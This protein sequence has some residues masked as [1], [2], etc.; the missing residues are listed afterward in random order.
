MRTKLILIFT[1]LSLS[2]CIDNYN[3]DPQEDSVYDSYGN[4]GFEDGL[5]HWY[6]H[7]NTFSSITTSN[8]EPCDQTLRV[9]QPNL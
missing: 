1:F 7:A 8:I 6:G 4:L 5:N 3:I 9:P 2:A